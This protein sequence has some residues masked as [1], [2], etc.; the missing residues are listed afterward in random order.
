[1][2]VLIYADTGVSSN[3]L[4]NTRAALADLLADSYDL[5]LATA[6]TLLSD[7]WESSTSLL[8]F[9]GGRDLPYCAS[10]NGK[11]NRR[12]KEWVKGG[13]K[14]LGICAGAYYGSGRIE[15]EVGT[16]LEVTGDRELDFFHG[17]CKGCARLSCCAE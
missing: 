7:P 10:L 14:Y 11:A 1:M 3:S 8:V 17:V 4:S 9:P 12:I 6:Q 16:G 15:F 2:N 13:G 5:K